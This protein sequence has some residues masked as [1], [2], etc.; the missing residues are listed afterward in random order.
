MEVKGSGL[1]DPGPAGS[2]SLANPH[3]FEERVRTLSRAALEQTQNTYVL[4]CA[5]Q[6]S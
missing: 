2:T 6:I 4:A 3:V 1:A 5:D